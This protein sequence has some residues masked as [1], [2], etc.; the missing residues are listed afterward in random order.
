VGKRYAASQQPGSAGPSK[1]KIELDLGGRPVFLRSVE[2]FL[3][4]PQ[5][6]QIILAVNPDA[7]DPFRLRWGDKLAFHGVQI[8]PGGRAERWETV[9]LALQAVDRACTHVAVHD[10]A[11]PLA[12][13][14]LIDRVFA[15]AQEHSAVVPGVPVGSTLKQVE[16]YEPP[17][18]GARS[19]PLAAILGPNPA[20]R[21]PVQRVVRTIDRSN[22]V[23]AQ[24]PQVF[25]VG[26]IRRA[27]ERLA[28][29]STSPKRGPGEPSAHGLRGVTDDA[30]LVEALGEPVYVVEGET[31]NL[32]IT[33]PQD[34]SLAA[35]IL[36]MRKAQSAVATA[37][38]R[39]FIDEED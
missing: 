26:L 7:I 10:A 4:H 3:N 36:E 12:S 22:L 13:S 29:T 39:L 21:A 38:K 37:R 20:A 17:A 8:V 35:A 16:T 23:E 19:D 5:V 27:Y 34:L 32:K 15:A 9:M 24:T 2:L 14:N 25:E 31:T 28:A 6:E 1:N 18:D 11:R 30:S 33:R